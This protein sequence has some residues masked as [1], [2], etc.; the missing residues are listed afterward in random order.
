M[1]SIAANLEVAKMELAAP[2]A[3]T[4]CRG[5]LFGDFLALV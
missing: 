2:S 1:L 3:R 5:H 4:S